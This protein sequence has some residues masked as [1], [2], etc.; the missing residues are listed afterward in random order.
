MRYASVKTYL[1]EEMS[2]SSDSDMLQIGSKLFD[3]E[4]HS[5]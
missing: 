5:F 3:I 4:K 1:S 2:N